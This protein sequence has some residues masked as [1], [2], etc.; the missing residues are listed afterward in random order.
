MFKRD[1]TCTLDGEYHSGFGLIN[2]CLVNALR[3]SESEA[4]VDGLTSDSVL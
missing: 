1:H 2:N 4:P 3:T